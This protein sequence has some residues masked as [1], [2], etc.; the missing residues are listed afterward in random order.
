MAPP[1]IVPFRHQDRGVAIAREHP[2]FA[3]FWKPGLGKTFLVLFIQRDRPRRTLVV[4]PKSVMDAAWSADAAAIGEACV[5]CWHANRAK[6]LALIN[7][8]G[9]ILL[10]TNYETF[11]NHINDFAESGVSRVV[12]DESSNLKNRTSR[13][14][15][16]AVL[17]CDKCDEV[18]MLSGTPFPNCPTE[19][20]AQLRAISFKATAGNFYKWANRYLTPRKTR[21]RRRVKLSDGRFVVQ[22]RDVIAGWEFVNEARVQ[23]F[24]NDVSRWSWSLTKE[25]CLDL[26][27]KTDVFRFVSISKDEAN[28]YNSVLC[29]RLIELDGGIDPEPVKLEAVAM[30]LRQ[31]T[32]GAV[33]A[34]VGGSPRVIGRSKLDELSALLDELGNEP[35]VIWAEFRSEIDRITALCKERGETVE[36][37]DGRTSGNAGDI[38]ARFQNGELLRLVCHPQACGHG[39]TLVAASYAIFFSLS[40]S[41][42]RHEQARDRIHRVGQRR[43]CTYFYLVV[44][45][46][47]D[48]G[49]LETVQRKTTRQEAILAELRRHKK[50]G[51]GGDGR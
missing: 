17:F 24:N 49:L 47:I 12:F 21:I 43:A 36:Y 27:E 46:T 37:I 28:A 48:E 5:V 11:V 40:F 41:S 32:G 14:S 45:G 31:I 7:T 20:W 8:P 26:P 3:F 34:E 2:R 30:K 39:V 1:K 51:W 18:Y 10:V 44:R 19:L 9:D 23:L 33:I 25:E 13:R 16:A 6:R 35:V 29:D 4:C 50:G 15:K 22:E 38:V 42:E